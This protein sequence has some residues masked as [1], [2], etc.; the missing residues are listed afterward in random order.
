MPAQPRAGR[1]SSRTVTA[2]PAAM[3]GSSSE[4]VVAVVADTTARPR[5]NST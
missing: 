5:P 3:A 4:R 1:A 2:I